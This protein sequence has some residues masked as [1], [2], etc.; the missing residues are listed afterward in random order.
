MKKT[1]KSSTRNNKL[2]NTVQTPT[3]VDQEPVKDLTQPDPNINKYA[4]FITPVYHAN[5][6]EFLESVREVA[7][8]RFKESEQE[9]PELHPIY[10]LRQTNSILNEQSIKPFIDYVGY[11]AWNALA[12]E[13]YDMPKFSVVFQEMWLQEHHKFSA[14]EE[15]VHG[16]GA[17]MVG[18]YF[19]E[20]PEYTG[21]LVFH[22]PRPAKRQINLPE[23][24]FESVS[25]SSTAVNFDPKPGDLFLAPSWV[26]HSISRHAGETPLR[27]VHITISTIPSEPEHDSGSLN[28]SSINNSD[29]QTIVI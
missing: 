29:G 25:D 28:S 19:L 22:D 18:F 27:F 23:A 5:K 26:P 2:D 13:G 1:K 16:F 9:H 6:P 7:D 15:H 10:P 12:S 8:R 24:N 20:C 14:H 11:T 3:V 4:Y 21:R 17:Q